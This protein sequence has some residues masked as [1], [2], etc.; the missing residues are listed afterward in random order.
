M[1]VEEG[2]S[3]IEADDR[4][5]L[6]LNADAERKVLKTNAD[7]ERKVLK[8]AHAIATRHA[9]SSLVCGLQGSK[10]PGE[11]VKRGSFTLRILRFTLLI[12]ATPQHAE[13]VLVL[14][15]AR[16]RH[17]WLGSFE[18]RDLRERTASFLYRRSRAYAHGG[19]DLAVVI[20]IRGCGCLHEASFAAH[21]Q[22]RLR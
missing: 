10:T 20:V 19:N 2:E 13:I 5:A 4:A 22:H 15:L 12:E 6:G 8:T 11:P 3:G 18:T 1:S 14:F 21:R 9:F 17:R 16:G 7:A